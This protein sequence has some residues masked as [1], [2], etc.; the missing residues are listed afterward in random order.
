MK[1]IKINKFLCKYPDIEIY[2]W[3]ARHLSRVKIWSDARWSQMNNLYVRNVHR[4]I[5]R[6]IH[7]SCAIFTYSLSSAGISHAAKDITF[8]LC[9]SRTRRGAMRLL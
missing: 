7:Y 1:T 8:S 3:S 4:R 6:V 9:E 5:H 2:I